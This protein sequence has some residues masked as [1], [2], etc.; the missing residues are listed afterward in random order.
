MFKA[1]LYELF[2]VEAGAGRLHNCC[3]KAVERLVV[4]GLQPAIITIIVWQFIVVTG[5]VTAIGVKGAAECV[6]GIDLPLLGCPSFH[7]RGCRAL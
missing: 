5:T 3:S 6:A 1:V 7:H 2:L 4:I